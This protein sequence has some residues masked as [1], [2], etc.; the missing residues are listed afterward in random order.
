MACVPHTGIEVCPVCMSPGPRRCL[1]TG[2]EVRREPLIHTLHDG[3]RANVDGRNGLSRNGLSCG[4]IRSWIVTGRARTRDCM[5]CNGHGNGPTQS[6]SLDFTNPN[7]EIENRKS[8]CCGDGLKSGRWLARLL[9]AHPSRSVSQSD[10]YPSPAVLQRQREQACV[11][12]LPV[13][14]RARAGRWQM[15]RWLG[16]APSSDAPGAGR[17]GAEARAEGGRQKK[18][19]SR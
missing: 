18:T 2:I 4:G 16:A 1:F 11:Y 14:W 9:V 17:S 12:L 10:S 3:G 7:P 15:E 6:E 5:M 13:L 19:R 8:C